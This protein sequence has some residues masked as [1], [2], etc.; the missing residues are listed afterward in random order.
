MSNQIQNASLQCRDDYEGKT[1]RALAICYDQ[2]SRNASR[3]SQQAHDFVARA[4]TLQSR[5]RC[6]NG[7]NWGVGMTRGSRHFVIFY[8][9]HLITSVL[10]LRWLLR[11]LLILALLNS[12]F[13]LKIAHLHVGKQGEDRASLCHVDSVRLKP[14]RAT[15]PV[16]ERT[17]AHRFNFY[18]AEIQLLQDLISQIQ[19]LHWIE[20]YSI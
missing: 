5:K 6:Q 19:L 20:V 3:V 4:F 17:E 18:N 13:N 12:V 2:S 15:S 11:L 14:V 10:W 9:A 8:N 16:R 7:S 1:T